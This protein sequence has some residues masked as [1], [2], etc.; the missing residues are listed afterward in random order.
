MPQHLRDIVTRMVEAGE[1]EPDIA[2]VIQRYN[3]QHAAPASTRPEDSTPLASA[4]VLAARQA[5]AAMRSVGRFA[6][7]HPAAIQKAIGAGMQGA[8]AGMGYAAGGVPGAIVGAMVRGVTPKQATIRTLAGRMAGESKDVARTAGRAVGI[9]EYIK[10][11]SGLNVKPTDVLE[12][13]L[14]LP[15]A[16]K[17]AAQQGRGILKI[18]GPSGEVVSGPTAA[19]PIPTKPTPP[20]LVGRIASRAGPFLKVLQLATGPTDLAQMAE[21]DRQDIGMM[22][23]GGTQPDPS[24]EAAQS[25]IAEQQA[26]FQAEEAKKAALRDRLLAL[27]KGR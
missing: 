21:P 7:E 16:E 27:M 23:I 6:A 2:A 22:G 14:G 5:P 25:K 10:K 17:Y 20:G 8:T 12:R 9:Q 24:A 4:T 13:P 11:T 15:A 26:L 1:S 19:Q 3:Q 18:L